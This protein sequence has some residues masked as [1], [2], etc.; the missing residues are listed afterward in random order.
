[1]QKNAATANNQLWQYFSPRQPKSIDLLESDSSG[2][3]PEATIE[4]YPYLSAIRE[5]SP[6]LVF[7]GIDMPS[8]FQTR[9]LRVLQEGDRSPCATTKFSSSLPNNRCVFPGGHF[10][11]ASLGLPEE[12][13][14]RKS[15]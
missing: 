15:S 2:H 9:L 1:M 10:P 6:D 14:C 5:K 13:D 4:R 11:E 7:L 8:S 12:G 3:Y